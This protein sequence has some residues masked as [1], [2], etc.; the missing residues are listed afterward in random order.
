MLQPHTGASFSHGQDRTLIHATTLRDLEDTVLSERHKGPSACN[1]TERKCP[2]QENPGTG[3]GFGA[4]GWSG[5][6]MFWDQQD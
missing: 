1:S 4:R 5:A 3:S 6:G 2:E